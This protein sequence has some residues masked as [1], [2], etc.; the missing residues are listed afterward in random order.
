VEYRIKFEGDLTPARLKALR[1]L[2]KETV[3]S[4]SKKA[5]LPE[6]YLKEIESGE[7]NPPVRHMKILLHAMSVYAQ[8]CQMKRCK[9]EENWSSA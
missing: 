1:N 8:D 6:K 5:G 7:A 9:F 3:S 2:V 4:L